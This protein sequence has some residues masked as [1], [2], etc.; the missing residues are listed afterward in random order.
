MNWILFLFTLQFSW[1]P[2]YDTQ[3]YTNHLDQQ[4]GTNLYYI[5]LGIK[6]DVFNNWYID[7]KIKTHIRNITENH[8]FLPLDT[9]Y[10]VGAGWTNN[11]ITIG[12]DHLCIHSMTPFEYKINYNQTYNAVY[13]ELF[14]RIE[15]EL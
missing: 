15:L 3:L 14:I 4:L 9:S 6:T 2:I 10:K 13:D 5:E 1:M 8:T 11:I 7:G 12:Y